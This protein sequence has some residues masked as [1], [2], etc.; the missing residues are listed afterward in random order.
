LILASCGS[1]PPS[2]TFC[3]FKALTCGNRA[4]RP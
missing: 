4:S 2:S 3:S 1:R